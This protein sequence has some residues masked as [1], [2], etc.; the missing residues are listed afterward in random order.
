MWRI[1]DRDIYTTTTDMNK[2]GSGNNE[3]RRS[4]NGGCASACVASR[5]TNAAQ[6]KDGIKGRCYIY[7]WDRQCFVVRRWAVCKGRKGENAWHG[8]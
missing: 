2:R 4:V 7:I 3:T 6:T 8:T 1:P 5:R